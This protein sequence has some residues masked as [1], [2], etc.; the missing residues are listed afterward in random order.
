MS[1]KRL[2]QEFPYV[3][4]A[5]EAAAAYI[6]TRGESGRELKG[7][8]SL[9]RIR[10]YAESIAMDHRYGVEIVDT[11]TWTIKAED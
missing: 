11:E 8:S 6:A 5:S 9:S 3:I 2:H 7:D 1:H 10:E 4:V